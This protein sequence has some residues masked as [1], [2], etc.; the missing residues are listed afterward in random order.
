M[1]P[2]EDT[3]ID[4]ADEMGELDCW[5]DDTDRFAVQ[6]SKGPGERVTPSAEMPDHKVILGELVPV[7]AAP[8]V[9]LSITRGTL[10]LPEEHRW[11]GLRPPRL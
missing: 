6:H 9:R 2:A 11:R 4:G 3:S 7:L 8:S 1:F 5:F 10:S